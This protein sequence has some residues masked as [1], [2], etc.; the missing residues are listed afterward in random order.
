MKNRG[1]LRYSISGIHHQ[2]TCF[3]AKCGDSRSILVIWGGDGSVS[4]NVMGRD[5]LEGPS[6]HPIL[7]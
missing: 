7:M 2:H 5:P 1:A 6:A 3:S 4:Q